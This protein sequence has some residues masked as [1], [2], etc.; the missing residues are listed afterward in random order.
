[1]RKGTGATQHVCEL[2][3]R[4]EAGGKWGEQAESGGTVV[5]LL[6]ENEGY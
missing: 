3:A 6:C 5:V 1:M 4:G 2:D